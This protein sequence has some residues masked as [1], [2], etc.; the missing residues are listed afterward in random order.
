[1]EAFF[2]LLVTFDA[3]QMIGVARVVVGLDDAAVIPGDGRVVESGN[4]YQKKLK[5]DAL[6]FSFRTT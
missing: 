6:G 5:F 4:D 1:M 2:P 3:S